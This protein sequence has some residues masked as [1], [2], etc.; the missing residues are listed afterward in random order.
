VLRAHRRAELRYINEADTWAPSA[1][2]DSSHGNERAGNACA[3]R[4]DHAPA[5]WAAR[6]DK[7][8]EKQRRCETCLG[9]PFRITAGEKR[10]VI[11]NLL[12]EWWLSFGFLVVSAAARAPGIKKR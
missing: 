3:R 8:Q 7:Y 12:V 4:I 5:N 9:G 11:T 10:L 2:G 6:A 1:Q